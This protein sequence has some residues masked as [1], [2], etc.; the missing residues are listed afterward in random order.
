MQT[1]TRFWRKD[2][3]GALGGLNM[4]GTDTS[5][6]RIWNTSVL[7]PDPQRGMLHSYM[8]DRQAIEFAR[9][10]AQDRVGR[11]LQTVSQFLPQL[12]T[13]MEASY[14]KVWSEDPWQLGAIASPK[15]DQFHW[16][17]PAARK[18]E[19]RVHFGGE[20]TSVWIGYMN[21]ALESGERCAREIISPS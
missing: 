13:E 17:W 2:P 5:A 14:V 19:G 10:P 4:V 18:A 7:Q 9:I 12:P 11:C 16:I 8:V 21:G 1:R 20:H 3:L 15:P 6:G